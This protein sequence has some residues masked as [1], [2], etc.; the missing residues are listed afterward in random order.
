MRILKNLG[1]DRVLIEGPSYCH[2]LVQ[3]EFLD[4]MFLDSFCI[5]VGGKAL[6]LG[7]RGN[8]FT[9]KNHPPYR[10]AE[11]IHAWA[12]FFICGIK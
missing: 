11:H 5:H 4:G 8:S 6:S 12:A 7:M 3:E 1:V 10:D 2:H 9:S